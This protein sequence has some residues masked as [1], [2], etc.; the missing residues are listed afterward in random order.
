[1]ERIKERRKIVSKCNVQIERR[2]MVSK[3]N[4]EMERIKKRRKM[5]GRC[6]VRIMVFNATFNNISVISWRPFLLLEETGV[7]VENY[8]PDASH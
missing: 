3:C 8:R 7:P 2:K 1:M 5:I 6:N 4:A